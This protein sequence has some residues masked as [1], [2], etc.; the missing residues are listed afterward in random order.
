MPTVFCARN[1]DGPQSLLLS[2]LGKKKQLMAR[3]IIKIDDVE[4]G[5]TKSVKIN[6]E[7]DPPWDQQDNPTMA[8]LAGPLAIALLIAKI[9]PKNL[10][11]E[12]NGG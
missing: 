2:V 8:Q 12:L 6:V 7:Y 3:T 5:D 11:P 9:D 4:D 1:C 10:P